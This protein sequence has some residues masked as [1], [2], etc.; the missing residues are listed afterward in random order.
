VEEAHIAAGPSRTLDDISE[1]QARPTIQATREPDHHSMSA[2]SQLEDHECL[3]PLGLAIESVTK[4]VCC[5][6]C[7]ILMPHTAVARHMWDKHAGIGLRVSANLLSPLALSLGLATV[8]PDWSNTP[9]AHPVLQG[10]TV[11]PN[12]IR[13]PHCSKIFLASGLHKH[14]MAAHKDSSS[15]ED[16]PRIPAQRFDS[17]A[18]KFLFEV[19]CTPP[20]PPSL[21][22]ALVSD[23]RQQYHD[24]LHASSE[25]L[26]P[27]AAAISPWL[28]ST[29]W[30]VHAARY[31]KLDLHSFAALPRKKTDPLHP[32]VQAVHVMIAKTSALIKVTPE[33]VLQLLNSPDPTRE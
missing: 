25:G 8:L 4:L 19:L 31:A 26:V 6:A 18:N 7:S 17:G 1:A 22:S 10:L 11:H 23:L 27:A 29:S 13:C 21:P 32:I 30:H 33:L 16:L 14:Q 9:H 5:L 28:L 24:T 12:C 15:V 20:P 3:T 2:V